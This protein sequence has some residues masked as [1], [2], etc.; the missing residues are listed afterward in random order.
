MAEH[1]ETFDIILHHWAKDEGQKSLAET[2]NWFE[3]Q[4]EER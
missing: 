1:F 2:L 4:E 3:K